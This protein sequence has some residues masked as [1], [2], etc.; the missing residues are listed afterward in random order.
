[1]RRQ[2]TPSNSPPPQSPG[3]PN[4]AQQTDED[5]LNQLEHIQRNLEAHTIPTPGAPADPPQPVPPK[6]KVQFLAEMEALLAGL[7]ELDQ[8]ISAI[9][10]SAPPDVVIRSEE[11]RVGK[12]CR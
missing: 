5:L 4:Y 6:S 11:R 9:A 10:D 3:T 12:E 8:N 7:N 1:M 2:N